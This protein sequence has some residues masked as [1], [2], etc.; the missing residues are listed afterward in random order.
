[1]QSVLLLLSDVEN[2]P[3]LILR[4]LFTSEWLVNYFAPQPYVKAQ[5]LTLDQTLSNKLIKQIIFP[6]NKSPD[7]RRIKRTPPL[8][9]RMNAYEYTRTH[10]KNFSN[11]KLSSYLQ[12]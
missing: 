6:F 5:N 1:M 9:T 10:L 2:K 3:L 8:T 7:P 12:A 11:A 4:Y